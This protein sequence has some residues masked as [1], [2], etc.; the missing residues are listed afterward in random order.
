MSQMT[1]AQIRLW[2]D[3]CNHE[4]SRQVLR[5]FIRLRGEAAPE[6]QAVAEYQIKPK[7]G[8]LWQRVSE[9]AFNNY[10]H[11]MPGFPE[12]E[13]DRRKLYT[14]PQPAAPAPV[15]GDADE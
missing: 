13:W 3:A 10:G 4:P 2:I 12:H 5:D 11:E 14:G 9:H 15:A 7:G 8:G 6:G 1:D